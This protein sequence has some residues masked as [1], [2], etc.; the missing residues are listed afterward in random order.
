V[1][2]QISSGLKMALL[3]ISGASATELIDFAIRWV[4]A[5]GNS[6]V[7]KI[8]TNGRKKRKS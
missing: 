6:E 4:K 2:V 5:K 8:K 3:G 1:D 7:A